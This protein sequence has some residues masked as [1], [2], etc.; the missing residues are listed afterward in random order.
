[1]ENYY[2][3]YSCSIIPNYTYTDYSDTFIDNDW[4][5]HHG[6][7]DNQPWFGILPP[8]T[9]YQLRNMKTNTTTFVTTNTSENVNDLYSEIEQLKEK[10]KLLENKIKES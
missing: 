6:P 1:M 2:Y 3:N 4:D 8:P 7:Y 9:Y 5:K 10:I